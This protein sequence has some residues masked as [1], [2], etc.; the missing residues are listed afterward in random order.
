MRNDA[1][2]LPSN[3]F[4]VNQPEGLVSLIFSAVYLKSISSRH[5]PPAHNPLSPPI[6]YTRLLPKPPLSYPVILHHSRVSADQNR[7]VLIAREL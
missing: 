6:H 1:S 3:L 7:L 4:S 2:C 5:T